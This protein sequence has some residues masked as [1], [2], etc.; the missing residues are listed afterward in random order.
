MAKLWLRTFLVTLRNPLLVPFDFPKHYK[1]QRRSHI[2]IESFSLKLMSAHIVN[3]LVTRTD[4]RHFR[5]LS[6]LI[7]EWFST[8]WIT[9]YHC[10]WY[11]HSGS[12][13]WS[14]HDS[15]TSYSFGVT[16]ILVE[17]FN[18]ALGHS[19]DVLRHLTE[20][21]HSYKPGAHSNC[22]WLCMLLWNH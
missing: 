16:Q 3:Q 14:Y 8:H 22:H 15:Y 1:C 13:K 12:L 17:S 11:I 4:A 21:L 2:H 9:Q 20:A 5:H 7:L 6:N 18:E 19:L 10:R